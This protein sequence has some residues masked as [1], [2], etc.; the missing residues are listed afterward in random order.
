MALLVGRYERALEE[1]GL[2][3]AA[4]F[5][6][7]ATRAAGTRWFTPAWTLCPADARLSRLERDL[8]RAAAGD[9]LV[10]VP[11]DPV[12][13]LARP[14]HCWPSPGEGEAEG[15]AAVLAVR[16]RDAPGGG[17]D[18][19]HR[20]SSG[21]SARPT[22]AAR[23]CA[24]ST[25]TK[26]PFDQAEVLVPA[27]AAHATVFHLL[28]ARTR[29]PV[30]F[31]DGVPVSFTSPGRLF[32]E[33]LDW[34]RND[35][36]SAHFCRLL[37][38]GDL[39]LMPG[40]SGTP[41]AA[42]TAC[43]HLR[44][45]MIGWK[46]DRYLAGLRALPRPGRPTWPGWTKGRGRTG[47]RSTRCAGRPLT[48]AIAEI[49]DLS[50]G[51]GRLLG[52]FPGAR[53][54]RT[55]TTS[56]RSAKPLPRSW[57]IAAGPTRTST[58][59]PARSCSAACPRSGRKDG[60]SGPGAEGGPRSA[61]DDG[62]VAPRRRFA[63][64][65]GA[66]PRLRLFDRRAFRPAGHLRRRPRRSDLPGPRPPGPG[67]AR[68]RKGGA[69]RRPADVR[70]RAPGGSFRSGFGPGVRAR[71]GRLRLPV[72]RRRRG[73]GVLSVLGRPAGLPAA[74]RRRPGSTTGLSNGRSPTRPGSSPAGS[75][76]PST[77]STGGWR[78]WPGAIACRG[79]RGLDP[80][81]LPRPRRGA[82]R[83]RRPGRRTLTEFDG[84]VDIGPLRADV[85]PTAGGRADHVRLAARAPGPLPLR[86]LPAAHPQGRSAGGG[87]FRPGAL[88]RSPPAGQ[89]HPRDPVRVHDADP[90]AAARRSPRP[91]TPASWTRSPPR[92]SWP[93]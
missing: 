39:V 92:T 77:R 88:A 78:G 91:G 56:G 47:R 81:Q 60:P 27:G 75:T 22:N 20:R 19:P 89:P 24:A 11:G 28:S 45:A 3:D 82:R 44:S 36:S 74:A 65:P 32:F 29:L 85:D 69:L 42:R 16:P 50:A 49:D 41:L 86:L 84:I 5:L 55:G 63:A 73:T 54:R 17:E 57:G 4:A 46:R 64:P 61:P 90:R 14:R 48:A 53:R 7:A 8:V 40:P 83:R 15:G 79:R 87:R 80:G 58:A 52:R 37:E 71:P 38:N 34:L 26:I 70:R 35:F 43:R 33:L 23:S 2:L 31:G 67:P 1:D 68:R 76:G 51:V 59:K 72:V 6:G 12:Y 25:R 30:T 9:R 10:L 18:A 66:P 62:C 13:G 93:G 21:R